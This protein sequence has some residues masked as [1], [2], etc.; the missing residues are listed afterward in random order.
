MQE[1]RHPPDDVEPDIRNRLAALTGGGTILLENMLPEQQAALKELQTYERRVAA[2][3][4]EL[5]E[6]LFEPVEAEIL[7]EM[8][9]GKGLPDSSGT[10]AK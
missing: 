2:K 3:N 7:K 1:A 8:Y 4:F 9:A 5:A 6:K 10:K